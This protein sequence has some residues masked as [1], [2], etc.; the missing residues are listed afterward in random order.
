MDTLKFSTGNSKI[1]K[2]A[3]YLGLAKKSVVSFDLP[4]GYTCPMADKCKAYANPITHKLVDGKKSVFRC[5]AASLEVAFTCSRNLRWH[6]YNL[7]K[8][9][10]VAEM[11]MLI[12]KSMPNW[13]KVVRIHSSG[14][15]FSLDYFKAWVIV[16]KNHPEINFFGY[17]KLLPYVNY[18]KSDNF[19]LVYSFGGKLD[20]MVT[21]EPVA[22]VVNTI[23]DAVKQG[24]QVSCQSNPSD[25]YDYIMNNRS[26]ALVLHGTQPAKS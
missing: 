19:H 2:L 23:N 21:N 1:N 12:E 4:A 5:Y 16:A 8:N 13:I 18:A 10:S 7:L 6:N 26:F 9:K 17:T 24:L 15:F 14:D 22:Y 20:N 25:D 3:L 11:V